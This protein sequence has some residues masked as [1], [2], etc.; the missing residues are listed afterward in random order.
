M[1]VPK[2]I[3]PIVN[4]D[5][6]SRFL[7]HGDSGVGKTTLAAGSPDCLML[8]NDPDEGR[9]AASQG[10]KAQRWIVRDYNDLT[11]AIDYLKHAD[12]SFKWA[13]LDNASIFQDQGMDQI[14]ED[15]VASKPHRSRWIPDK[16]EYLLNQQRLSFLIRELKSL[17][18]NIG[19]ICNSMAVEDEDGRTQIMPLFQGGQGA[20][21]NKVCGLMG[22]VGYMEMRR[23][24]SA[25]G[26]SFTELP[27]LITNK[28]S[29]IYA[30][31]RYGKIGTIQRPT[32]A[33]ILEKIAPATGAR[34]ATGVGTKARPAVNKRQPTKRA[35]S[36]K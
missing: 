1:A 31:D 17:P 24:K 28:T 21:S 3:M 7:L 18:M 36:T 34:K 9:Y 20:F 19:L 30:K 11:E 5:G 33:K 13:W 27:V 14:M 23:V 12:H 15:L 2:A 35:A 10:T 26:N 32:M 25:D 16:P 6:Y 4:D 8:F 22:V 29:K